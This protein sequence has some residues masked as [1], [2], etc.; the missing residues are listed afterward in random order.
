MK[1]SQILKNHNSIKETYPRNTKTSA[2]Q[3]RNCIQS[4]FPCVSVRKY[5]LVDEKDQSHAKKCTDEKIYKKRRR[6]SFHRFLLRRIS[7]FHL[8]IY[9]PPA[10]FLYRSIS[11]F[12]T[13]PAQIPPIAESVFHVP[14]CGM[15]DMQPPPHPSYVL[16]RSHLVCPHT[17]HSHR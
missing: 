9:M 6:F 5:V 17:Y 8:V 14:S 11:V 10:S 4:Y 7:C 3:K 12:H 2:C 15:D 13:E 1:S 16:T